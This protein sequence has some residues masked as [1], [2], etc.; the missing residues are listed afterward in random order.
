MS[1]KADPLQALVVDTQQISRDRLAEL[2]Q[3]KVWLDLQTASVHLVPEAR[4]KMGARPA[5]LLAL[6]GK[7]ALSLLKGDEVDA[8][9]PKDLAEVTGL[10]GNTVRPLLMRLGEEGYVIRRAKGYA[11]HN[12]ALH[13]V[14]GAITQA[15]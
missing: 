3:G 6:L 11:V 7:K 5:V 13:L 8:M 10:K 2:L 15:E 9:S 4:T 14:A 1:E 12:A